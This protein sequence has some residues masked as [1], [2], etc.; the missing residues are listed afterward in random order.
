MALRLSDEMVA[1]IRG[2]AAE[3]YP[4]ECC[5]ALLGRDAEDA[6]E[7]AELL[8]LPNRREDSPRNRFSMTAEDVREA[9]RAARSRGHDVVGWYHSHPDHPAQP[10]EYDRELAWPWYSYVIV[11]VRAG[12]PLGIVSWRL[13]DDRRR[14][15]QEEL[16]IA[17]VSTAVSAVSSRP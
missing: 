8:P 6:R 16:E 14:F 4:Y 12:V 17:S 9:E 2:H 5:G 15:E 1:R 11:S 7:V 13:S 10:S 3:T